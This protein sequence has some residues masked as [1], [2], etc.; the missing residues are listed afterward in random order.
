MFMKRNL[1]FCAGLISLSACVTPAVDEAPAEAPRVP[2]PVMVQKI[3]EKKVQPVATDFPVLS[4][5][6]SEIPERYPSREVESMKDGLVETRDG[7]Y[8]STRD[9]TA[10]AQNERSQDVVIRDRG[11][12]FR[13]QLEGASDVLG[14]RIRD[15][16]Q[17]ARR[18][19][20]SKV[21]ELGGLPPKSERQPETSDD[22]P[23]EADSTD[24]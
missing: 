19:K 6:P 12:N 8:A 5:M 17:S 9:D 20:A 21:P 10:R 22:A 3:E 7:L 4:E 14:E 15:D 24:G 1:L 16:Q 2:N 11:R 23:A 13:G 18:L